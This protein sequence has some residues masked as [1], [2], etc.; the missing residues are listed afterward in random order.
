MC[1][2]GPVVMLLAPRGHDT[3]CHMPSSKC[4]NSFV[5]SSLTSICNKQ[6]AYNHCHVDHFLCCNYKIISDAVIQSQQL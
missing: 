2:R 6:F 5:S 1:T 3:Y 4:T